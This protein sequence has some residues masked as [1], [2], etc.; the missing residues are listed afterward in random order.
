M[1]LADVC[2]N[3]MKDKEEA[4]EE[5][6]RAGEL[7]PLTRPQ[8]S[9]FSPGRLL[10]TPQHIN[11]SDITRSFSAEKTPSKSQSYLKLLKSI[12]DISD[13][14]PSQSH[15]QQQK[16]WLDILID[17]AVHEWTDGIL[18]YVLSWFLWLFVG[19]VFYGVHDF[20][21]NFYKGFYY[22]V[23]VGYSIGWGVLHDK[24]DLSKL[25]SCAYLLVGAIFVSRWLAYL[26][27][28]AVKDQHN[29]IHESLII[30]KNIAITSGLK[31]WRLKIYTWLVINHSNVIIIYL[32]LVYWV[33]AA[34]WSCADIGWSAVDGIYYAVSSMSTGGLYGVP[35]DSA[36]HV[37]LITGIF[38]ATGVPLMGMAVAN[39]ATL[40]VSLRNSAMV[41]QHKSRLHLTRE[42]LDLLVLFKNDA[43]KQTLDRNE[44]LLL[45]LV[46]RKLLNVKVIAAIYEEFDALNVAGGDCLAFDDLISKHDDDREHEVTN[47]F[48]DL[49]SNK[50]SNISSCDEEQAM[51]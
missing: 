27:E 37:F 12:A 43:G 22:S 24:D 7:S 26:L 1:R 29:N 33:F 44:F 8:E 4:F 51:L 42:E 34:I 3:D 48:H 15:L 14:R 20:E 17:R 16:N 47:V 50:K 49:T 30:R 40:I 6:R 9:S 13:R 32:W 18:I 36:D 35:A 31:G 23:N 25:F 39:I 2:R 28:R 46:K 38:A 45:K 11:I 5:E 41:E 10:N 19:T 21:K